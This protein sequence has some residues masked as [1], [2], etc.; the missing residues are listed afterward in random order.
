M[1]ANRLSLRNGVQAMAVTL[2]LALIV[3]ACNDADASTAEAMPATAE[4]GATTPTLADGDIEHA[5]GD[6]TPLSFEEF[7]DGYSIREGLLLSE[8]LR[9]LDGKRVRI[10]GYMAPPLKAELDFFV[11]TRLRLAYCPFCSTAADWPDD[12]AV[13]YLLNEPVRTTERPVSV[14]GTLELGSKRDEETGMV[15]LVRIYADRYEKL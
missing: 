4:T 1:P 14:E 8:K 6:A 9:G 15:S 12:I 5:A 13:I 2:G 3:A 7:Y 11:L 10:D